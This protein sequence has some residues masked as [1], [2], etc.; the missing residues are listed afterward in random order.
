MPLPT[1]K[2]QDEIP[3]MFRAEY[4]EKDGVFVAK[5]EDVTGLKTVL[6]DQKAKAKKAAEKAT[7]F[8]RELHELRGT[9]EAGKQGISSDKLA[10]IRAQ[11][12]AKFKPTLDELAATQQQLRSLRLD[13]AVKGLYAKADMFDPDAAWKITADEYDLTDDGKVILKA[14]PT[15]D[16][17][18]HVSTALKAKYPFLYKGTQAAGGGAAGSRTAGAAGPSSKPVTQ[19]TPEEKRAYRE[20]H[21]E[22]S[23]QQLFTQHLRAAAGVKTA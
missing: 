19:W 17:E 14:D 9:V 7:E 23:I 15:A 21:G 12:E 1:F 4:E 13:S 11:T 16:V 10:E 8:E 22:D 6:A 20:Q 5:V 18:K 2:T 3:E